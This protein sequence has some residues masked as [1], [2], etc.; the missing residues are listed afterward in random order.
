MHLRQSR[1]LRVASSLLYNAF[2]FLNDRLT[3]HKS[4]HCGL[5][6]M[7]IIVFTVDVLIHNAC[8][9]TLSPNCRRHTLRS[10]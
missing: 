1:L 8:M 10:C 6:R 3:L 4:F 5:Q 2:L 9:Q 7:G